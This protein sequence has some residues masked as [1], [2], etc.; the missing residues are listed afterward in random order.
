M[1]TNPWKDPKGTI[2][3]VLSAVIL[4]LVAVCGILYGGSKRQYEDMKAQTAELKQLQTVFRVEFFVILPDHSA[5]VRVV[6]IGTGQFPSVVESFRKAELVLTDDPY[7]EYGNDDTLKV[8]CSVDATLFDKSVSHTK[9][10]CHTTEGL[11]LTR[12]KEI[13]LP[14]SDGDAGYPDR[15]ARATAD[16]I[17]ELRK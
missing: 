9:I 10:F 11:P 12:Q 15:L 8:E 1:F 14:G 3:A 2:I 4:V 13:I 17:I 6:G 16:M 7:L 5:T